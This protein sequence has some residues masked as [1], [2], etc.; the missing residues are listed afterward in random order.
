MG[1]ESDSK[2]KDPADLFMLLRGRG[3]S[4]DGP[5][6]AYGRAMAEHR[7]TILEAGGREVV[8][9][10]LAVGDLSPGCR[11][12]IAGRI[13]WLCVTMQ[14][15]LRCWFCHAKLEK[16]PGTAETVDLLQMGDPEGFAEYA[17]RAG[18]EGVGI[19]GGEPL[20]VLDRTLAYLRELK[21]RLG[22]RLYVWLYTNGKLLGAAEAERLQAA[23]LDEIRFNLAAIGYDLRP[24]EVAAGKFR[25]T[26]EIPAI[27]EDESVRAELLPRLA[28]I[29]VEHLHLHQV[30]GTQ[31]N[32]EAL[33]KRDYTFAEG[34]V[35]ESAVSAMATLA[36]AARSD[37]SPSV[38]Y[39][40]APY[41]KWSVPRGHRFR[42]APFVRSPRDSVT[43][44]GYLRRLSITGPTESLDR[45]ARRLAGGGTTESCAFDAAGRLEVAPSALRQVDLAEFALTVSYVEGEYWIDGQESRPPPP[46][47][48]LRTR[49]SADTV[50]VSL[51]GARAQFSCPSRGVA[52]EYLRLFLY[53][54]GT[55][56]EC[57]DF[58]RSGKLRP[59]MEG[60]LSLRMCELDP[61]RSW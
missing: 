50:L 24:C 56:Q 57:L 2:E 54:E 21:R 11:T 45:L 12:C 37:S 15:N 5:S 18:I 42:A 17:V 1:H 16:S 60:G 44:A 43:A 14:C 61:S 59:V 41:K 3:P 55:D 40:S 28:E 39:C 33:E 23:G 19:I 13:S 26:V 22:D 46:E 51:P 52:E 35:V 34:K 48:Q 9:H 47:A 7:A 25:V 36:A 38:M 4:L 20:M 8:R 58:A 49:L 30:Y 6:A 10:K 27:P 32:H 31:V 29:G 53:S